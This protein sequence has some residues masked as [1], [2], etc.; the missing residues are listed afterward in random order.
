MLLADSFILIVG[1]LFLIGIIGFFVMSVA[2]VVRFLGFVFRSITGTGTH[3][4]IA[5]VSRLDERHE[6][7][8]HPRCGNVNRTGARFCARCGRSLGQHNDVDAY[9]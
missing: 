1:A 8:P 6:V 5:V 4:R 3:R 9:G 2:L 7:C